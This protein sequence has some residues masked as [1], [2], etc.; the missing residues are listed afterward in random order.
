[1]QTFSH[2]W[3]DL[4]GLKAFKKSLPSTSFDSDSLLIQVF[5]DRVS[6]EEISVLQQQLRVVFPH[7]QVMGTTTAGNIREGNI[8]DEGVTIV[9]SLFEKTI[10][11]TVLVEGE[12]QPHFGQLV[13]QQM[14]NESEDNPAVLICFLDGL[15]DGEWFADSVEQAF[16]QVPIAGGLAGDDLRFAK[17][18]VFDAE[19]II[20]QGA[21]VTGLFSETLE[22]YQQFNFNW[23]PVGLKF[24]VT[25]SEQNIVYEIEGKNALEFYAEY[26]GKNITQNYMPQIAMEFPLIFEKSG[27]FVARACLQVIDGGALIYAGDIPQ[28]TVVQFG[29]G[30]HHQIIRDSIEQTH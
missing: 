3:E 22:V 12:Q 23:Q 4:E 15:S 24:E 11:K 19:N 1:M 17:T 6:H 25:K 9:V 2:T 10:V 14:C 29:L 7:A 8:L 28:G 13:R 27:I 30:A 20:E 16:P 21:V 5:W 18:C 26:L